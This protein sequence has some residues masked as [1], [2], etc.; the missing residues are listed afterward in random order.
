MTVNLQDPL[1]LDIDIDS[2]TT[3][4]NNSRI[5]GDSNDRKCATWVHEPL[6]QV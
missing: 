6:A 1:S 2:S 5:D 4:S 3:F